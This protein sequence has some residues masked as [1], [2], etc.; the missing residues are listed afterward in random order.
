LSREISDAACS[1]SRAVVQSNRQRERK[2]NSSEW[3]NNIR[4]VV[5]GG[6][7]KLRPSQMKKRKKNK[8]RNREMLL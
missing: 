7:F 4:D 5:I 1:S 8:K 2:E 3:S 6:T